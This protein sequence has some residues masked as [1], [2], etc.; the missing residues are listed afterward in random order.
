MSHSNQSGF[1]LTIG[2][3]QYFNI[4][5][6]RLS[7]LRTMAER[8]TKEHMGLVPEHGRN[9]TLNHSL[10][11]SPMQPSLVVGGQHGV[12]APLLEAADEG[13]QEADAAGDDL[14]AAERGQA[15]ALLGVVLLDQV[16]DAHGGVT[17]GHVEPTACRGHQ[18][19]TYYYGVLYSQRPVAKYHML[20]IG[21]YL[22]QLWVVWKK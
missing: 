14:S 22:F 12:G 16:V 4:T 20:T 11:H 9:E 17:V 19:H 5:L 2:G 8:E 6:Y 3:V 13:L 1:F 15:A 10:Q 18:V 7:V 21:D